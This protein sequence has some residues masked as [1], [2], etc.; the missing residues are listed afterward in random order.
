MT[1]NRI[2][3]SAVFFVC[4]ILTNSVFAQSGKRYWCGVD[5]QFATTRFGNAVGVVAHNCYTDSKNSAEANLRS[6]LNKIH[7]AQGGNADLIELDLI[8]DNGTVLVAHDEGK[9]KAAALK[10]VLADKSIRS[11][12]QPLFFELKV[13][14]PNAD[15]SKALLRTVADAK[16]CNKG[17]PVVFRAFNKRRD[18]LY[19]LKSELDASSFEILK[20][21]ARFH[22]LF[23]KTNPNKLASAQKN[24]LAAKNSGCAGVEF[25]FR[26]PN[27]FALTEYAKSLG[28]GA[29]I[30]TIPNR[31]GEVYV[32]ALREDVDA[33]VLDYPI[34][35]SRREVEVPN[36]LAH[37]NIAQLKTGAGLFKFS[38]NSDRSNRIRLDQADAPRAEFSDVGQAF[39]GSL[40]PFQNRQSMTLYDADNNDDEGYLVSAHLKFDELSIRDGETRSV[41][42]KA[43][44]GGFALELHN[45][46]GPV[47]T[48]LRFGVRVGNGYAY[49]TFP[50]RRLKTQQGYFV[51][52]AYDGDGRV[53]LWVDNSDAHTKTSER[54][55]EVV[56][57]DSP[58]V[59]GADPQGAEERRFFFRGSIQQV[60]I[61]SWGDH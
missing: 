35:K 32:A 9:K 58:I 31:F 40:F 56:K 21:A 23:G 14:Q 55:G 12:D 47:P 4:L 22:I 18:V 39:Y 59:I 34:A 10:N 45:P 2:R 16:I 30:F 15:F 27:L 33:L 48:V 44:A 7:A 13:N 29:T 28:L 24:I 52:G 6:T 37:L 5:R 17:R 36:G 49:A 53:R 26:A 51:I 60:Q 41:V 3:L 25:H 38:S 61:Q 46:V 43:D 50:A 20:P 54:K 8:W 1:R 42:S 57:N 11:G 19:Q